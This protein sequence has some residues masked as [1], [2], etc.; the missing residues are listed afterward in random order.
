MIKVN[1]AWLI[2]DWINYPVLWKRITPGDF[3]SDG[4][5]DFL[6]GNN[7]LNSRLDASLEQPLCLFSGDFDKNGT[8]EQL[9]NRY[10]DGKLLPFALRGDLVGNMPILKKKYLQYH[11]YAGQ[12]MTDIFSPEQ[13]KDAVELQATT[14][15][16]GVLLNLG[17]GKFSYT[18]LP[19]EAQFAPMYGIAVGDF[20]GDGKQDAL[21]AGNFLGSKPEFGY[22]DADYGLFL[23]GD[24]QGG[25][26]AER[27]R[28]TGFRID[29]EVR[30][31]KTV[32][33]G[34]KSYFLVARN[35]AGMEIF[36]KIVLANN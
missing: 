27:S 11:R 34:G 17:D 1:F 36:T 13:M 6:V 18:P 20:D 8:Y 33:V 7:G 16:S 32:K 3:N 9:L 25:F 29:G 5:V 19:S 23:K 12:G 26:T 14:L 24:G 2:P 28:Q 22:E 15:A 10:N 35:N 31:I 30:D 4:K 21:T